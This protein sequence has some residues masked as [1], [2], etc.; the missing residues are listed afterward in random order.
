MIIFDTLDELESYKGVVPELNT[1]IDVMDH[2]LPYDETPGEYKN[3][4]EDKGVHIV[5]AFLTSAN[6]FAGALESGKLYVEICLEGEEIVSID[7]SVFKLTPGRFV[8]YSS[9]QNLKRGMMFSLPVATKCVRF[10][11]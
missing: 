2:S 1:V 5:D 7:G 8:V 4:G 3:P 11:F 10:V 6:G 9:I